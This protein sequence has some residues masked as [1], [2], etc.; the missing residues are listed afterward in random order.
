MQKKHHGWLV[1][2]VSEAS[3]STMPRLVV[4]LWLAMEV[5][6]G[7]GWLR[8]TIVCCWVVP[9]LR[10]DRVIVFVYILRDSCDQALFV[11]ERL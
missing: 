11:S 7:Q 1:I 10:C 3:E 8:T 4:E 9:I 2:E 5:M 6:V